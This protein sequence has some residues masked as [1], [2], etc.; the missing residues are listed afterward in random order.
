MGLSVTNG[1]SV[2]DRTLK[3]LNKLPRLSPLMSQLLARLTRRNCEIHELTEIV[4]KD[5]VLSAQI[6]QLA[7][8]AIFARLRPVDSVRHAIAMVGISTMRKFA[9]GSSIT[10]LFSRTKPA[11][12][13][14]FLRFN[15][16]S[17]ATAT[18]L[19][20]LAEEVP[21]ESG[22]DAFL[23]G[24]LHDIGKLLIAVSFPQEYDNILAYVAVT[25]VPLIEAER[26]TLGI[27]HAELSAQAILRWEL[28][29]AIQ[30]AACYHHEPDK[31]GQ[32]ERTRP[33]RA[34]LSLG[35]HHADLF[36][37]HL[38][39]S[40][41]PLPLACQKAD[42]LSIPGFAFPEE[43]LLERFEQEIQNLGDL[44]H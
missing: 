35:V 9:L 39:M 34:P 24:L 15:L 27:D 28:S 26:N 18:L 10:N 19:E 29:E 21:F 42:T 44:F 33:N 36:V 2:R 31:A 32:S 17:V 8:S 6:L 30:S 14:S 12:T 22:G 16:H 20:L 41:L 5:P 3:C 1:P 7:N 40:V 38:G 11:T 13:F 43:L 4:E 37:N 23:A 25:G